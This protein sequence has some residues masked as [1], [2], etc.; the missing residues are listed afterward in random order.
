[1]TTRVFEVFRLKVWRPCNIN[2]DLLLI[3]VSEA[4]SPTGIIPY[5]ERKAPASIRSDRGEV[6]IENKIN[7]PMLRYPRMIYSA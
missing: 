5:P 3:F 6:S 1:M 7:R 4:K 2:A